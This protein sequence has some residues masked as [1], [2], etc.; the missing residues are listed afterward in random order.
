MAD[1]RARQLESRAPSSRPIAIDLT[2]RSPRR[3]PSGRRVLWFRPRSFARAQLWCTAN[4]RAELDGPAPRAQLIIKLRHAC[5]DRRLPCTWRPPRCHSNPD[6]RSVSRKRPATF[7]DPSPGLRGHRFGRRLERGL[8]RRVCFAQSGGKR[9]RRVATD[10]RRRAPRERAL[11]TAVSPAVITSMLAAVI[12]MIIIG[13]AVG[14]VRSASV[15][16]GRSGRE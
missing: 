3:R 6:G 12:N 5:A 1:S 4:R 14:P 16:S 9:A 13:P 11:S 10:A 2:A 7:V 15:S 8:P